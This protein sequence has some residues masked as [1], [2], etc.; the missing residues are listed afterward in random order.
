MNIVT[1]MDETQASVTSGI[2]RMHILSTSLFQDVLTSLKTQDQLLAKTAFQLDD[3]V[4]HFSFFMLRLV[5][6]AALDPALANKLDI[7]IGDCLDYQTFIHL[8]E[9]VA[10]Y[11]TKIAKTLVQLGAED[12]KISEPLIKLMVTA[13]NNAN[14]I[15]DQAVKAF[16]SNDA[17]TAEEIIERGKI[18]DKSDRKI[19]T[20]S[21]L[22]EKRNPIIICAICSIRESIKRIAEIGR[23]IALYTVHRSFKPK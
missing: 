5:K 19:A 21:F 8:I 11:A 4:D 17:E 18:I 9:Q 20:W 2:Q 14:T 13:G 23:E 6:R 10:D 12:L 7:E 16:F 15:Y 3:D 1:L 22:H